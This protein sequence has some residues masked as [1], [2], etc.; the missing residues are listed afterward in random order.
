MRSHQGNPIHYTAGEAGHESME[1]T[2]MRAT[3][4]K[5]SEKIKERVLS[6]EWPAETRAEIEM[7]RE[8]RLN[9]KKKK[10]KKK[11]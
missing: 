10:S 11:L 4:L 7:L 8:H 3:H 5:L 2:N 9:L 6:G 1:L